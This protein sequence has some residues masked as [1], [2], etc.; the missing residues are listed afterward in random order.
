MLL[1]VL[2]QALAWKIQQMSPTYGKNLDPAV[3]REFVYLSVEGLE[4]R[5][6]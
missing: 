4:I 6:I 3:F 5:R 1:A 2:S